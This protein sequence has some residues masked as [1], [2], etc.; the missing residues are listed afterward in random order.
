MGIMTLL[1]EAQDPQNDSWSICY[2]CLVLSFWTV[3]VVWPILCPASL[4]A[5]ACCVWY[6]PSALT[7]GRVP[8]FYAFTCCL[9]YFRLHSQK[10]R[11]ETPRND[12]QIIEIKVRAG[13]NGTLILRGLYPSGYVARLP[14]RPWRA[15]GRRAKLQTRLR[16][17]S[18]G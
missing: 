9:T 1:F 4:S 14:S 17:R 6:V 10:Y 2:R 11:E 3:H 8:C 13:Y 12:P 7:L 15:P 5:A 18:A 16:A